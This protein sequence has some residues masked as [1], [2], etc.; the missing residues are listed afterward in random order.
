MAPVLHGATA[1][2][3]MTISI[4]LYI[5][6]TFRCHGIG[7]MAATGDHHN[8]GSTSW[9]Q[10]YIYIYIHVCYKLTRHEEQHKIKKSKSKLTTSNARMS[11]TATVPSFTP[12]W[13][14]IGD[15]YVQDDDSEDLL[16]D[17]STGSLAPVDLQS[18]ELMAQIIEKMGKI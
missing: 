1:S 15:L 2:L 9:P 12:D 7:I 13:C 18:Y 17:L 10:A 5:D 8:C 14:P 6:R 3:H 16:V 4:S 11:E